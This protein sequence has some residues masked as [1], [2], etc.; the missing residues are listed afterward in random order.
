MCENDEYQ[1]HKKRLAQPPKAEAEVRN[2]V[3]NEVQNEPQPN[4]Q[5]RV[6]NEE[7]QPRVLNDE[8]RLLFIPP[9]RRAAPLAVRHP[10]A[11]PRNYWHDRRRRARR[12]R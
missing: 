9:V 5:P 10:A 7:L 1:I 12:F 4:P 3:Q 6:L 8:L 2:E 11:A